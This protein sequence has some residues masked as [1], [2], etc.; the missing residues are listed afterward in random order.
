MKKGSMQD[1]MTTDRGWVTGMFHDRESTE[2]A[3]KA[4]EERG[5]N[6]DEINLIMSDE[7]RKKIFS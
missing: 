7:T 3:Y 2:E 5:Y 4:L 1:N 6:R